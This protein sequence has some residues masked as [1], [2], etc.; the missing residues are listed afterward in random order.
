MLKKILF[1][2]FFITSIN[3]NCQYYKLSNNAKVSLITCGS[4]NEL[5]SIYGHTAIRF[6]DTA[7]QLDVVYN[8]GNFD[9]ATENFYLKFVKGDLQ[10]FV[11]ACTYQDFMTEYI[12]TDRNVYEQQLILNDFQKQELFD[13]INT[14]IF[15]DERFYTYKFIDKNCTTMILDKINGVYGKKTV[16]KQTNTSNSYRIILYSFLENHFWENFGINII[17]GAK[18]DHSATKIFLPKELMDNIK[19]SK[20]NN[21][22][23]ANNTT[24]LNKQINQ[25]DDFSFFNSIYFYIMLLIFLV[26]MNQSV[27]NLVYFGMLGLIGIFFSTVGFYSFHDEISG[28]YNVLIFNPSLLL[29]IYFIISNNLKWVFRLCCFNIFCLIIYVLFLINKAHLAMMLPMIFANGILL[30][31]IFKF[32]KT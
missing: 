27:V 11:A 17:F 1:L 15:S 32:T 6:L 10:Y 28:N 23:I 5:Y 4:G 29:L 8:Y 18:V 21:K 24:V 26:L 14:S 31:R 30:L 3:A 2:F 25:I 16:T 9:F 7:N 20:F 22:A 19:T 13:S 12:E